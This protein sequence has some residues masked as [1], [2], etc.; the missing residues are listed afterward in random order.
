[1]GEKIK[2]ISVVPYLIKHLQNYYVKRVVSPFE[3]YLELESSQ[4]AEAERL[5]HQRMQKSYEKMEN[6]PCRVNKL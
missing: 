6:F 5:R 2:T 1:M 4:K 3:F